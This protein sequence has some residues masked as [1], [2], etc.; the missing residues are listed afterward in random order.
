MYLAWRA[1]VKQKG[2]FHA[3]SANVDD[4]FNHRAG[5]PIPAPKVD[6]LNVAMSIRFIEACRSRAAALPRRLRAARLI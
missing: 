3:L 5:R 6:S 4:G 1:S 2:P